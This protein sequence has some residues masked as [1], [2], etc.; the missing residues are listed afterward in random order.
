MEGFCAGFGL[1]DIVEEL[2]AS[3]FI[4]ELFTSLFIMFGPLS[5]LFYLFLLSFDKLLSLRGRFE[6]VWDM[7]F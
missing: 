5:T 1:F 3:R 6:C 2:L 4:L 7:R